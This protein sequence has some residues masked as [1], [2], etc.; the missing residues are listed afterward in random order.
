MPLR[1]EDKTK[2]PFI[3]AIVE[4]TLRL[5]PMAGF[6]LPHMATEDTHLGGYFFP[7]GTH[8][9]TFHRLIH[10]DP[11]YFDNPEKFNPAR[12]LENGQFKSDRHL[13]TFSMGKRR[14]PGEQLARAEAYLFLASMIRK[15]KFSPPP[16]SPKI[17]FSYQMGM[18]VYPKYA[19]L[20]VQLR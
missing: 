1:L 12:F 9:Y 19:Q 4:E 8:V 10:R 3:V 5:C 6:N 15:F 20:Q 17:D 2:T 14:C 13:T 11:K 7:K 18:V 16:Q